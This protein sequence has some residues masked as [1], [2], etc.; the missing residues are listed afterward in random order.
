MKQSLLTLIST[1]ELAECKPCCLN[2]Q[3]FND[4]IHGHIELPKICVRIINTPEFLRLRHIKQLG[5]TYE[6]FP[7]AAHNRFEHCLG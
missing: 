6:V 4:P 7:G 3:V 1:T 2:F 5:A